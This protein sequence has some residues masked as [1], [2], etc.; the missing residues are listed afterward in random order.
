MCGIPLVDPSVGV[1]HL[2]SSTSKRRGE[3]NPRCVV[4]VVC[5]VRCAVCGVVYAVWYVLCDTCCMVYAVWYFMLIQV[6]LSFYSSPSSSG[7]D[8]AQ[9]PD[10]LTDGIRDHLSSNPHFVLLASPS[11]M[12]PLQVESDVY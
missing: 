3:R 7:T 2:D 6:F 1:F 9:L 10:I 4:C 11:F 12:E 5:G 8:V